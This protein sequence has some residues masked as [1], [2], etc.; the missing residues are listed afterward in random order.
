MK[1]C[2]GP[3]I[4]KISVPI[5]NTITATTLRKTKILRALAC[6]A[7]ASIRY[8][9]RNPFSMG[10]MWK[11]R[12]RRSARIAARNCASGKNTAR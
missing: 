8:S 2:C 11:V 4:T 5:T 1:P 12:T 3:S 6:S 7:R 9:L 10:K